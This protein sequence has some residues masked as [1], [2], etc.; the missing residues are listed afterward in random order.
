MTFQVNHSKD[1]PIQLES[2]GNEK[3]TASHDSQWENKLCSPVKSM[4]QGASS[5]QQLLFP[6]VP[7]PLLFL[8]QLLKSFKKTLQIYIAIYLFIY[9]TS[10]FQQKRSLLELVKCK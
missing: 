6:R 10:R 8:R 2:P 5:K 1:Y 3:D 4:D 9:S 7:L